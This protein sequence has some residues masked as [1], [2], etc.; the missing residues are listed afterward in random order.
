[1]SKKLVIK[2][3][4][5]LP[6]AIKAERNR[7]HLSQRKLAE[8]SGTGAKTICTAEH[9]VYTPHLEVLL[10]ILKALEYTSIEFKLDTEDTL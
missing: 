7:L 5:E 3:K 2:S 1:M 6:K 4:E 9:G 8:I 10:D